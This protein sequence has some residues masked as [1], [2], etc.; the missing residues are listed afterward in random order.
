[1]FMIVQV[2]LR[3]ANYVFNKKSLLLFYGKLQFNLMRF[4]DTVV[5]F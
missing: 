2:F 1:M 4:L 3:M 5:T